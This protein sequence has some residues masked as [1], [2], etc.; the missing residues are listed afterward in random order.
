MRPYLLLLLFVILLPTKL[1]AQ[2]SVYVIDLKNDTIKCYRVEENDFG[3]I[4]YKTDATSKFISGD[5]KTIK[6]YQLNSDSSIHVAFTLIPKFGPEFIQL[7]EKGKICLYVDYFYGPTSKITN[8]FVSKNQ[9]DIIGIKTN[10]LMP[11]DKYY[12]N[13]EFRKK[14]FISLLNDDPQVSTAYQAENSFEFDSIR[15][16]IKQYNQDAA[17]KK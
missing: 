15:K 16:Y 8:Y 17:L 13:R 6:E 10:G 9:G 1:F 7:L 5:E 2:K 12:G 11:F 3:G 14:E 4:R